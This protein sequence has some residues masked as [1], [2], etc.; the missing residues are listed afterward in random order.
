MI[1]DAFTWKKALTE[2]KTSLLTFEA[3]LSL[4]GN[5]MPIIMQIHFFRRYKA[6]CIYAILHGNKAF[7]I[8]ELMKTRTRS[9]WAYGGLGQ[10]SESRDHYERLQRAL[11]LGYRL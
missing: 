6:S 7:S 3:L 9:V 2:T 10:M 11:A 1:L 5:F 8:E 4:T